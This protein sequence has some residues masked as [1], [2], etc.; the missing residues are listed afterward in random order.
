MKQG[1]TIGDNL[2]NGMGKALKVGAVAVGGL[3]IAGI[4]TALVKGFSRLNSLDQ[5]TAKL[6][7][8]GHS[9]VEVKTIMD[10][11]L[12]SVKGTAF[13]LDEAA[14]VSAAAVAAGI[15]PGKELTGVLKTIADTATIAGASMVDTGAIFNSVAARG[16]LQGDDLMQLQSRGV[17]VLAFL[18]KH[19][20]ITA[21]AAS[22]MVSDGKVD[23]QNFNA[24]MQENLGGAALKSGNTFTGAMANV[25]A[26]IGRVGANLLSGLFPQVKG[27]FAGLITALAPFEDKAKAIGT[28]LGN[29]VTA[30]GP[31]VVT[32]L[33]AIAAGFKNTVSFIKDNLTWIA[34]LAVVVGVM[35]AAFTAA[36]LATAIYTRVTKIAA[37]VQLAWNASLL[38]N[39]IV[40]IVVAIAA[41]VAGL[42]YFFT[43]TKL[44]QQVWANF[45]KFLVDAWNNIAAVASTVWNAITGFISSAVKSVSTTVT[46]VVTGIAAVW[47]AIWSGIGSFFSNV[48]AGVIAVVTT[49]GGIFTT[50]F[51]SIGDLFT[52]LYSNI[53]YPMIYGSMVVLGL[54]AALI[55]WLWETV[56]VPALGAIG[57][58]FTWLYAT[59]IQPVVDLIVAAI[60]IFGAAFTWIYTTI[61]QPIVA[62]I[63][64]AFQLIAGVA[65]TVWSGI[66]SVITAAVQMVL[67]VVTAVVGAVSAV[68]QTVWGAISSFAEGVWSGMVGFITAYI[69][70]VQTIISTVV[71]V[72]S[73]IWNNVWSGISSFFGSVWAGIVAAV[74]SFGGV[75]KS[76]FDGIAGFVSAAFKGVLG[77]V[78]GPINALIGLINGVIGGLN[79]IHV[80]IPDWVP[81]VGGQTFGLSIPRLPR[82]ASGAVIEKSRGGS[83]VNVGEGRYDE[84]VLPLGGPQLDKIRDALG[85]GN[86]RGPRVVQNYNIHNPVSVDPIRSIRRAGEE[87]LAGAYV[88]I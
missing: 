38:S 73:G 30:V 39:P 40:L 44:G 71:G 62:L 53:I 17:P 34:P 84:A 3:A 80:K 63:A 81:L 50:V 41:L 18:A 49:V 87:L 12:S 59:I 20:G 13:G 65:V 69:G 61:I 76:A 27:G 10:N 74:R 6:N 54:F 37:A 46:N 35:A 42:I 15:K 56:V 52:W 11:A 5:A 26:S 83:L 77:A 75:F 51:T 32:V 88:G 60:Q 25:M 72:I 22:K 79:S 23:F 47:N 48:W 58:L 57:A 86:D 68:W 1:N 85:D 28:V 64:G 19:Y 14:T 16:K 24:A 7:G 67:G 31:K 55:T 4:G 66:V 45:T 9:A 2:L 70:I 8:L 82:L 33:G 36:S 21:A 78:K 29:W 43:Q